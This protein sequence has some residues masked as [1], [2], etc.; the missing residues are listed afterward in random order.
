ML[1]DNQTNRKEM[2]I[3]EPIDIVLRYVNTTDELHSNGITHCKTSVPC[4]Q[5][6]V[7]CILTVQ[8]L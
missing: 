4:T 2:E 1:L 3:E 7:G 5:P 8:R 6:V